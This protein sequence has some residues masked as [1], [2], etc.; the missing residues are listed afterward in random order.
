[1]QSGRKVVFIEIG[2][3]SLSSIAKGKT[4]NWLNINNLQSCPTAYLYS[5]F[6]P[7]VSNARLR[8]FS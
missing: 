6:L 3:N 8:R 4:K 7:N 5:F 2:N 1:M